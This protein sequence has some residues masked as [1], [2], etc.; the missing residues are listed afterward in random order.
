MNTML[1]R[2]EAEWLR[3]RCSHCSVCSC[4]GLVPAKQKSTATIDAQGGGPITGLG[5]C[6]AL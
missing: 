3:I 5:C 2:T 4:C 6:I 1:Q